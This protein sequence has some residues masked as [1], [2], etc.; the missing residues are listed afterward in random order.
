[1]ADDRPTTPQVELDNSQLDKVYDK[2]DRWTT[3]VYPDVH[4]EIGWENMLQ[5]L[6]PTY[7]EINGLAPETPKMENTEP[8]SGK[9]TYCDYLNKLSISVRTD[10]TYVVYICGFS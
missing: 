1:M 2:R 8:N 6:C 7:E 5:R 3:Y 9:S 4:T 10:G